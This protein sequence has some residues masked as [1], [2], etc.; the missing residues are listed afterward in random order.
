MDTNMQMLQQSKATLLRHSLVWNENTKKREPA[1][2]RT[3]VDQWEQRKNSDVSLHK[4]RSGM[5]SSVRGAAAFFISHLQS[6]GLP[7]HRVNVNV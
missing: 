2:C 7:L 5:V 6:D 4:W 3:N 1:D